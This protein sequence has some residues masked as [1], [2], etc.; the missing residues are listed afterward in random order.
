MKE[1]DFPF[2]L[3]RRVRAE[4]APG[5]LEGQRISERPCGVYLR[6]VNNQNPESGVEPEEVGQTARTDLLNLGERGVL[7]NRKKGKQMVIVAPADL[8]ARLLKLEKEAGA[9]G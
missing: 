5:R 4:V 9:S 3:T 1:E 7:E 8:S 2:F 6:T